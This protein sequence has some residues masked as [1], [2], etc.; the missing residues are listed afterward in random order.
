[1]VW[2]QI[3]HRFTEKAMSDQQQFHIDNNILF[4]IIEKVSFGIIAI[5]LKGNII[6][7][8]KQAVDLL[9]IG[10]ST[11][12]L[13]GTEA[14]DIFGKIEKLNTKLNFY[15]QEGPFD[16]DIE[17]CRYQDYFLNFNARK[18]EQ[19]LIITVSDITP[20]KKKE[21]DFM[22][23]LLEGQEQ[24]RKRLAREIHDGI[25]PLLSTVKMNLATIE[26]DMDTFSEGLSD[27][28]KRT[29]DMIDE[30]AADLR[31]ISHNLMPK[32]L[33]D[34]G[35]LEALETKCEYLNIT[36]S[37]KVEFFHSGF[38]QRLDR[39][40]EL[41]LYRICQELMNNTSKYANATKITLQLIKRDTSI[42]LMYEDNGIGFDVDK[43][44]DGIGLMNI[45]TRTKALGGIS[46]IDSH[47][48]KGMT[49]TVEIP[50]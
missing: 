7:A 35:L 45:E 9:S 42:Q 18:I 6:V 34:F 16:F 1:M 26:S 49:A 25:G 24:E 44:T 31:A 22:N 39:L 10:M 46:M 30:T 32:V 19:G 2:N 27:K 17:A 14:M 12:Q 3:A 28:F 41:A 47:P 23:S 38:T 8:N 4:S 40:T 13:I 48:G 37:T 36:K 29:Y 33:S 20:L 11:T 43:S 50:L 15:L 21:Q 5:D